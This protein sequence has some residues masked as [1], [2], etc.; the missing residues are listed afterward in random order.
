MAKTK[1]RSKERRGREEARIEGTG[2][3]RKKEGEKTKE[4]KGGRCKKNS[5][6]IGDM[7]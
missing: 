4:G 6:R 1:R 5:R 3:G 7:E 2:K